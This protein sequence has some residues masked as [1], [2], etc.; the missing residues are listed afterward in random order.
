MVESDSPPTES[1]IAPVH[2]SG[3]TL[4]GGIPQARQNQRP[5]PSPFRPASSLIFDPPRSPIAIV[6]HW[7]DGLTEMRVGIRRNPHHFLT[8]KTPQ[9]RMKGGG[10]STGERGERRGEE[11]EEED[12]GRQHKCRQKPTDPGKLIAL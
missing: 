9:P 11:E 2:P 5:F 7:E 8:R 3:W 12:G 4:D 1:G 6:F 10:N